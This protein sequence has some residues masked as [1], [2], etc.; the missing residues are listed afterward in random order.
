M[1][2]SLAATSNYSARGDRSHE[3]KRLNFLKQGITTHAPPIRMDNHGPW[4]MAMG[5]STQ[6]RNTMHVIV[7]ARIVHSGACVAKA[8]CASVR[9][10]L[11][12]MV[13]L[14]LRAGCTWGARP[15][16]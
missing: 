7:I 13:E 6:T 9:H 4:R 5:T 14:K 3:G 12:R 8:Q 1:R 11:H 2:E 10:T 16:P 15:D